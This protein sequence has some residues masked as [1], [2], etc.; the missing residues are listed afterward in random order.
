MAS[1]S[2]Q[3][4][5]SSA[6]SGNRKKV[7]VGT[8]VPSRR[9]SAE[10]Q[11]KP[12]VE[13]RPKAAAQGRRRTASSARGDNATR[14]G[15]AAARAKREERARRLA[16]RSKK[17][18]T[19]VL[20]VGVSLVAVIVGAIALYRAPLF[21][22]ETIDV[23]GVSQLTVEEVQALAAVPE[24]A[25]LLRYP[26]GDIVERLES[27]P[28]IESVTVTRDFPDTLLIRVTERTP[29]AL[30]DTGEKF[31]VVDASGM[32]LG[33][34][35]FEESATLVV[36]RDVQG[37]DPKPG[38]ESS[39]DT[40]DSSLA[41]LMGIGEELKQKVRAI[42]APSVDETTLLTTDAIEI[43]IGEAVDLEEKAFLALSIMTEQAGKVIFIDVRSVDNPVSRG[44]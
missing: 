5:G 43:L 32:V 13:E 36:I 31:W 21:T 24:D 44:L 17:R 33:E 3:R 18:R 29:V 39:S 34:Q 27:D 9:A 30:V 26:G 14:M 2:N 10:P 22:I 28:W 8:G 25:T 16:E 7:H 12:K 23:E 20:V 35:S 1:T 37:L 19:R 40:L 4:S 15:D 11:P 38:R 41:V 42:S 6:N